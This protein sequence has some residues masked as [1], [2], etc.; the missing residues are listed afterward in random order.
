VLSVING[1]GTLPA[2]SYFV[3][4]TWANSSGETVPGPEKNISTTQAGALVVQVPV[5]P[6]AN[7]IQ[8]KIYI[9]STT[10]TETLQAIQSF[11]FS[12]YSQTTPLT[13]G[14]ALPTANT[15]TC[16]V[17]FNDELQPSYTGYNVTFTTASG[18]TVP[19]FPQKWYLSGG[20]AGTINVGTGSPL[21]SGVVVYP[22]AIISNPVQAA[23]QSLNGPLNMNGFPILNAAIST[24]GS[25]SPNG[26]V[27]PGSTSGSTTIQAQPVASGLVTIPSTTDT[28]VGRATTDTLTNKTLTSPMILNGITLNGSSGPQLTIDTVRYGNLGMRVQSTAANSPTAITAMPS[29][30]FNS[31]SVRVYNASDPNNTGAAELSITGTTA[32]LQAESF[33]TGTLPSL[34]DVSTFPTLKTSSI[35]ATGNIGANGITLNGSSGPQ[36]TID[37]GQYGNTGMRVQSTA[38]GS[39][40]AITVMPNGGSS[41]S[42]RI[43]SGSDPNNTGAAE[44]SVT[45]TTAALQAES[46]GTGLLPNVFDVST[47]RTLKTSDIIVN[48]GVGILGNLAVGTANLSTANFANQTAP[49][50]PGSG[51]IVI[52]GDRGTGNLAC[53]NSSGG[54]CLSATATAPLISTSANPAQSGVVRAAAGDTA[55]AFR[56]AANNGD[57]TGLTKDGSDVVQVGGAAGVKI[58]SGTALTTSNQTGTGSLVMSNNPTL[59]SGAS[60]NQG[61]ATGPAISFGGAAVETFISGAT[62]TTGCC[63]WGG[64]IDF[65]ANS[66]LTPPAG[67]GVWMSQ[68]AYWNGTNWKQPSGTNGVGSHA[69]TVNHHKKF[70]FNFAPP[71]GTDGGT[72]AWTEVANID[73]SGR[74]T[75]NGGVANNGNG[76]KHVR[77]ASCTT[78]AISN[79]AC[80]QVISWPGSFVDTN[81][82]AVCT[83]DQTGSASPLFTLS[84][85]NKSTTTMSI[86]V[87]NSPDNSNATSG[88]INCIAMHD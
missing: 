11:P 7:A 73:D 20:S 4:T 86:T 21:Y 37:T 82:T 44:L 45:P 13:A 75:L 50:N 81:Y 15:S 62:L 34:F 12:N 16:S 22:Q 48:G 80:N 9:S 49:S 17:R 31:S 84:I 19:G 2:G 69:F 60:F 30:T 79:A 53:R 71:G 88:T 67:Y 64:M 54:S 61:A 77:V 87:T 42:V 65:T 57:I 23:V 39:T 29:G 14:S 33:G 40:T 58:N 1:G 18:A 47:F 72:I 36:L 28:L 63:G 76:L 46:F 51:S 68:N 55:V 24:T 59:S 41:S 25:L 32:A 74:L 70:S 27:L 78:P 26:L 35:T 8:W 56:N 52:Y 5:N 38:T 83:M 3:R 66:G 6:P 85:F 43:Y 10:G